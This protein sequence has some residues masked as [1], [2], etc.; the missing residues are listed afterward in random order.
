MDDQEL[1]TAKLREEIEEVIE[2]E[3]ADDVAWEAAD[4]IY[5]LLVRA[6]TG[7]VTLRRI[8]D[9]LRSRMGE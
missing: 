7:G 6:S 8:C 1:I 4:V 9:E 5:H 2:A 3:S